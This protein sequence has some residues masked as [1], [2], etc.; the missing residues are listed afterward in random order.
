MIF[1]RNSVNNDV[2]ASENLLQGLIHDSG[3]ESV[4]ILTKFVEPLYHDIYKTDGSNT[5]SNSF[6]IEIVFN[7]IKF[8]HHSLFSIEHVLERQLSELHDSNLKLKKNLKKETELLNTLRKRK[9]GIVESIIESSPNNLKKIYI[10]A[11]FVICTNE[12]KKCR[13]SL[14]KKLKEEHLIEKDVL[15]VWKNMK[16]IRKKTGINNTGITL[17]IK[18]VRNEDTWERE[19]ELELKDKI[20][21]LKCTYYQERKKYNEKMKKLND[22]AIKP[23]KPSLNYKEDELREDI[24]KQYENTSKYPNET[25]FLFEV[26]YSEEEITKVINVAQELNRQKDVEKTM[27]FLKLYINH[28]EVCK[29]KAFQ[30]D[31]NFSINLLEKYTVYVNEKIFSL[32]ILIFEKLSILPSHMCY[33]ISVPIPDT[34]NSTEIINGHFKNQTSKFHNHFGV[35]CGSSLSDLIYKKNPKM[36]NMNQSSYSK[37]ILINEGDLSLSITLNQEHGELR[38]VNNLSQEKKLTVSSL[39]GTVLDPNNPE[40]SFL[41]NLF[42]RIDQEN[43]ETDEFYLD[44][45]IYFNF[46]KSPLYKKYNLRNIKSIRDRVEDQFSVSTPTDTRHLS[47]LPDANAIKANYSENINVGN[48]INNHRK[49]SMKYLQSINN[50]ISAHIKDE[51]EKTLDSILTDI[52]YPSIKLV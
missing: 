29:T 24:E 25:I 3:N 14:L 13:E 20:D 49:S 26:K 41:S 19:I 5:F 43:I 42:K 32:K 10:D 52:Q 21:E 27:M 39:I 51:N 1:F 30:L 47:T 31:T 12:M 38:K 48:V 4:E 33:E 23:K 8:K 34:L 45:D 35:G 44:S 6:V 16:Y 18:K 46:V 11:N 40:N 2:F 9:N 22:K 50:Y 37:Q 15:S 36:E 17:S 7:Q 28:K